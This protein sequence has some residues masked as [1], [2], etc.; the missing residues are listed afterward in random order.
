[1][2]MKWDSEPTCTGFYFYTDDEEANSNVMGCGVIVAG[3][4]IKKA[5]TVKV[6]F[7][8]N[9]VVYTLDKLSYENP[10]FMG[11]ITL[12]ARP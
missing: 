4:Q 1:M 7:D 8:G 6:T 12:P 11:P 2:T 9:P 3:V 5:G 10:K